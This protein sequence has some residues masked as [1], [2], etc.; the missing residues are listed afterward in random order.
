M[1][2][3]SS[4]FLIF[5]VAWRSKAS[6]AS[7]RTMPQPLSVIWMS[8]LPPASITI[9]MRVEPA[10]RAFSSNSFTTEAGRSTTSPA[11]ILLATCSGRTWMRPMVVL[12]SQLVADSS[13]GSAN[14]AVSQMGRGKA[15]ARLDVGGLRA[16]GWV[17]P[18]RRGSAFGLPLPGQHFQM[19][20]S[21]FN[22]FHAV[23]NAIGHGGRN[24]FL[25]VAED[26]PPAFQGAQ[27]LR[28]HAG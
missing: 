23:G 9:L 12:G 8:F 26:K 4:A 13:L 15:K 17:A 14:K 3:R 18:A 16:A 6:R 28:Q 24:G 25:V 21:L 19:V 7:S 11:A 20:Q 10:S 5:E 22:V 27:P 2:S 1:F